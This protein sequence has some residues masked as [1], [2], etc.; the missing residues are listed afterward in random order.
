[1]TASAPLSSTGYN[2]IIMRYYNS[3]TAIITMIIKYWLT[4]SVMPI[5]KTNI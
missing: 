3:V 2:S 5:I 4:L 1:M